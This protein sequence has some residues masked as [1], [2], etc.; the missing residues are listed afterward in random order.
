MLVPR[1]AG[2]A[3]ESNDLIT[4]APSNVKSADV[5]G[6]YRVL[7]AGNTAGGITVGVTIFGSKLGIT[8]VVGYWISPMVTSESSLDEPPEV[9]PPEVDPPEVEPPEVEPPEVEPP[10]DGGII[11]PSGITTEPSSISIDPS[12]FNCTGTETF[13]FG[14]C[15]TVVGDLEISPPTVTTPV[16]PE[17]PYGTTGKLIPITSA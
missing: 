12:G 1:S 9:D 11:V 4:D 2:K 7:T 17:K 15:T 5:T 16:S 6:R 10:F 8:P 13:G 14:G 3:P